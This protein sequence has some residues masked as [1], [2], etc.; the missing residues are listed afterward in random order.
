LVTVESPA[1]ASSTDDSVIIAQ[2]GSIG[3]GSFRIALK[4]VGDADTDTNARKIH[5]M[6][7]NKTL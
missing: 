3:A 1:I 6:V 2:T 5:Y 4:N 7:M